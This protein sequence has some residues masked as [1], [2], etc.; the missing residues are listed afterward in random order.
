MPVVML[1]ADPQP[2]SDLNAALGLYATQRQG[3]ESALYLAAFAVI[4]PLALVAVPRLA[5]AIAAGPNGAGSA[6]SR[7]RFSWRRSRRSSWSCA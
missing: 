1:V 3:A 5:N 7:R 2:I 6:G 4:L